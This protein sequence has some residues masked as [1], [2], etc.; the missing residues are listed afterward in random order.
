MYVGYVAFR[1]VL[2]FGAIQGHVCR[3][4][5]VAY[6]YVIARDLLLG[7]HFDILTF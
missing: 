3:H 7:A 5:T 6:T 4:S 1:T 2:G